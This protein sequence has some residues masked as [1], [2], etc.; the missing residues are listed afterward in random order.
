MQTDPEQEFD[1]PSKSQKKR[2][3]HLLQALG[4]RLTG[5]SI[6]Q[7]QKLEIPEPTIAA[8]REFNRLPNSHGAR[9][10]QLQFIGKLMR[11]SDFEQLSAALDQ[12]EKN[13]THG[14]K[15]TPVAMQW[16]DDILLNGDSGINRV[17]A[18]CPQLQRRKLRQYYRDYHAS[19]ADSHAQMRKKMQDYLQAFIDK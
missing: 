11:K 3:A 9:R 14:K 5:C 7:L 19:P 12:L 4:Q 17:L 16:V 1:G 8:I 2:E 13:E 18:S 10:R 15:P 6:A